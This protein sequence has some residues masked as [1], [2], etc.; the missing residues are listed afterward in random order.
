MTGK[1]D[2]NNFL[3][4]ADLVIAEMRKPASQRTQTQEQIMRDVISGK[5]DFDTE[6]PIEGRPGDPIRP[7][8]GDH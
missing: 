7:N 8:E 1:N 4:S 2:K 3:T 5:T 6:T